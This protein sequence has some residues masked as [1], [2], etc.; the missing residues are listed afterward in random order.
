MAEQLDYVPLPDAVVTLMENTWKK[1]IAS[2][3]KPVWPA[4]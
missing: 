2:N 3:G 4:K 1:S